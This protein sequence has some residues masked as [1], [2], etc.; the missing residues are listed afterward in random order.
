MVTMAERK[1][2][3]N[4]HNGNEKSHNDV[5]NKGGNNNDWGDTDNVGNNNDSSDKND[6]KN[7][8]LQ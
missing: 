8:L 6:C 3:H 5:R 2:G 4:N 1:D 7:G